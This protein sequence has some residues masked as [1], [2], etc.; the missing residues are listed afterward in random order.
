MKQTSILEQVLLRLG[1]TSDQ[2][3]A[4]LKA[5]NVQGVRN[6]VRYLNP[7]VRYAQLQLR[8]DDYSLDVSHG[9]SMPDYFLRMTLPNG[10]EE[11][12]AFPDPVRE[13]LDDFNRGAH[14]DLE[15][16]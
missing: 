14:G 8:L 12:A 3:A 7:I 15:L 11:R 9:D 4:T 13:F 16:S 2:V 1:S 6:T 5:H 10:M